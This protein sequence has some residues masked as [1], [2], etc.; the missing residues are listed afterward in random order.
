M[1]TP[2]EMISHMLSKPDYSTR[3]KRKRLVD[4]RFHS[5]AKTF[6]RVVGLAEEARLKGK[7]ANRRK[8]TILHYMDRV[9]EEFGDLPL[10]SPEETFVFFESYSFDTYENVDM[11]GNLVLGAALW[12]LDELT[13]NGK[14]NQA[15]RYLPS[16]PDDLPQGG[17]PHF[18][19][20]P[21]YSDL[22]IRGMTYR[23]RSRNGGSGL[24]DEGPRDGV[25]D[26][27]LELIGQEKIEQVCR[28]FQEKQWEIIGRMMKTEA[29]FDEQDGAVIRQMKD[30]V[31]PN[32]LMNTS[33]AADMSRSLLQDMAAATGRG[34]F[35]DPVSDPLNKMREL[36]LQGKELNEKRGD[37][38]IEFSKYL[39]LTRTERIR[40]I[41]SRAGAESL[42]DFRIEDPCELCFALVVLLDNSSCPWLMK[43]GTTLMLCAAKMLPWYQEKTDEEIAREAERL[44]R[45]DLPEAMAWSGDVREY[46][47]R[48]WIHQENDPEAVDFYHTWYDTPEGKQN[49]AQIIYRHSCGVVPSGWH[50]CRKEREKLL[51]LG[52]EERTADLAVQWMEM[53]FHASFRT[54]L[55]DP[56]RKDWVWDAEE[57]QD[58]EE[59]SDGET[60][61]EAPETDD[62]DTGGAPAEPPHRKR[63]HREK[64][65]PDPELEIL[66]RKSM[67]AGLFAAGDGLFEDEETADPA[68]EEPEEEESAEERQRT[69]EL[70]LAQAKKEIKE[71]RNALRDVR[72][73][74]EL[75]KE[76][77]ERENRILRQEHRELADLRD[78]VFNQ[79]QG[80]QTEKTTQEIPYPYVTRK[81]TVLFG[82]HD[83]FLKAIKPLLP[84]VRF[85]DTAI[86]R[87]SPDI[88]RNA[89]VIWVQSNCI[90]HTQFGNITK[91]TRQYGI[92]LRYFA[93]A[94]AEKCAEQLVTEDQKEG[95]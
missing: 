3:S 19:Y 86:Y 85:V 30:L 11:R 49:L 88:V 80:D 59:G 93:Y 94:S 46:N 67:A 9:L 83:T 92:Q 73:E 48:D 44:V 5:S 60:D 41:G 14:L 74:A 82:G 15:V 34:D 33:P 12:M 63:K 77:T 90:S 36:A 71:L 64:R 18:F 54:L 87:F 38:E 62:P 31:S 70:E 89:D 32:V 4:E 8:K 68:M 25:F 22:L 23:I 55:S 13:R 57:T 66:K 79:N 52:M 7:I 56:Q 81:R 72:H 29:W 27:L 6:D 53:L 21:R 45:N 91:L 75:E 95:I 37:V 35:K 24:T 51:E 26:A 28:V 58:A 42:Q 84:T 65:F 78:L 10:R 43:S 76:R 20:H 50:P 61:E 1:M 47:Q 39:M 16:S 69:L 17:I 40:K 2:E